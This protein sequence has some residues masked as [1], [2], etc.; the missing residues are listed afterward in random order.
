MSP[1]HDVCVIGAHGFV[2]QHLVA[3]LQ[4]RGLR[5]LR[6]T[7][8]MEDSGTPDTLVWNYQTDVPVGLAGVPVVVNCGK[9]PTWPEARAQIDRLHAALDPT[10][11]CYVHLSS[12]AVFARA[13]GVWGAL[14]AGDDYIRGKRLEA[15]HVHRRFAADAHLVV[16]PG[17]LLGAG[18]GW[19]T[20][21]QDVSRARRI[22]GW[23][24]ADAR[25]ESIA[26]DAFCERL[27]DALAARRRGELS[28]PEAREDTPTWE[29]LLRAHAGPDTCFEPGG[30]PYLFFR[31][32][33]K[34]ALMRVLTL[35]LLPDRMALAAFGRLRRRLPPPRSGSADRTPLDALHVEGMT[36]YYVS[37]A[38]K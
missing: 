9:A 34:E 4:R 38:P 20:F 33:V 21:L 32:R 24:P 29:A 35:R 30:A 36:K 3:T 16:Y 10:R 28:I 23:Q 37:Q 1:T 11:Q 27:A 13:R 31:S 8:R 26:I 15:R 14:I 12:N 22:E 18:G 2:G 17:V 5:V 25:S 7:S 6:L 19:D